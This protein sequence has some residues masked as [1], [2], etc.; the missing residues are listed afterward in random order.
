VITKIDGAAGLLSPIE[1]VAWL[2]GEEP[3]MDA[4]VRNRPTF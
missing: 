1:G 3:M 2:T 4:V